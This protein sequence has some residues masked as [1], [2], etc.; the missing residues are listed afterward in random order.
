M[1]HYVYRLTF[2]DGKMYIGMRSTRIQPK[3]D[4][5][6]LGS[7]RGLP[8]RAPQTCRKEIL[9]EFSSRRDA[10]AY[11]IE[12]IDREDAVRSPMYYNLR[13]STYDRY[14]DQLSQEHRELISQTK[15]G[16]PRPSYKGKYVGDARTPAQK[17]ADRRVSEFQRGR[18]EPSKG[19]KGI[20]NNGF[21]PWYYVLPTGEQVDVVDRTKEEMASYFGMTARQMV[22]RFHHTNQHKVCRY[23]VGNAKGYIFGNLPRPDTEQG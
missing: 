9:R 6:Y 13:R 1:Y 11:E 15:T 16:K 2:D 19:L 12:C 8:L 21:T 7:G 22:H 14:G 23:T 10:A 17:D 5:C 20:H 18:K 3:L 4:T